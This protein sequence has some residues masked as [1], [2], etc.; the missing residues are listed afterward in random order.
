[1]QSADCASVND[2][3][4]SIP[5]YESLQRLVSSRADTPTRVE[6]AG[7]SNVKRLLVHVA[8]PL[9]IDKKNFCEIVNGYCLYSNV[10]L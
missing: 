6:A 8:F 7:F 3:M 10:F 2:P 9:D 4:S 1:M 5:P